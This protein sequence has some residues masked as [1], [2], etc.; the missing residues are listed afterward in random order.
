MG[1]PEKMSPVEIIRDFDRQSVREGWPPTDPDVVQRFRWAVEQVRDAEER[2][3]TLGRAIRHGVA[4]GP[5]HD[6]RD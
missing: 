6:F 1:A 4:E 2:S 3:R 5:P